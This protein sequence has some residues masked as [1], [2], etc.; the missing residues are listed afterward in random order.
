M[1]STY[2]SW[3]GL[4]YYLG[5]ILTKTEDKQ[6]PAGSEAQIGRPASMHGAGR[7]G[8]AHIESIKEAAPS[9]FPD[10]RFISSTLRRLPRSAIYKRLSAS[11]A[12]TPSLTRSRSAISSRTHASRI[13]GPSSTCAT[14][15]T[16][17][18][19]S[20]TICTPTTCPS[21][22]SFTCKR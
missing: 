21:T 13:S 11:H 6:V 18:K 14:V 7:I 20:P 2:N 10:V 12:R 19:T 9:S 5:A 3:E 4:F 15:S 1:F 8:D 16:W 22:S 17:W